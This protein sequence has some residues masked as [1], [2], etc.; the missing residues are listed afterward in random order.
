MRVERHEISH[1]VAVWLE[2]DEVEELL[3][4][5]REV[6]LFDIPYERAKFAYDLL[7]GLKEPR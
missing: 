4:I 6:G 7:Q 2:P 5:V 1:R 3:A